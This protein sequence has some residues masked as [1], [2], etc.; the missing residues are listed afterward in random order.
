MS[1]KWY[2]LHCVCI[3]P[4]P[5]HNGA[6]LPSYPRYM[7]VHPHTNTICQHPHILTT[8]QLPACCASRIFSARTSDEHREQYAAHYYALLHCSREPSYE[9]RDR[10]N[11]QHATSRICRCRLK[12]PLVWFILYCRVSI[13][14]QYKL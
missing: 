6:Y 9:E 8:Q 12:D 10:S 3:H 5:T 7:N 1:D 4:L 14:R 11:R 13:A 2:G